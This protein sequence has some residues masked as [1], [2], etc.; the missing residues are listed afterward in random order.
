MKLG[1]TGSREGLKMPQFTALRKLV[2]RLRPELE[3]GHHGDCLGADVAFND[4]AVEM[5]LRRVLHPPKN[6]R[7]RAFCG[8]EN[9]DPKSFYQHE[10]AEYLVRDR[11]I[12]DST[13]R[14]I[15]TPSCEEFS[16]QGKR[17]GTW[18]TIHYAMKQGKYI[19][20]IYPD[21]VVQVRHEPQKR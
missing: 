13:D 21:G 7:W 11:R 4:L 16:V 14:L 17:S 1:F 18:Y 20:V 10:P 5:G 12:V 9:F 15:G 3:E 19:W 8:Q 6:T 2:A